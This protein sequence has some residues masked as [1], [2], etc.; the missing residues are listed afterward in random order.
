MNYLINPANNPLIWT[1][2]LSFTGPENSKTPKAMDSQRG[3]CLSS[4]RPLEPPQEGI[5]SKELMRLHI[6]HISYIYIII[7]IYFDTIPED[8]EFFL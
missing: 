5:G 2:C 1:G 4:M 3:L 7:Y 6:Y 8:A